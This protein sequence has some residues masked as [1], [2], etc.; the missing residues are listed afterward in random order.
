MSKRYYGYPLGSLVVRASTC[1]PEGAG[2]IADLSPKSACS[3][4]LHTYCYSTVCVTIL[5]FVQLLISLQGHHVEFF[6]FFFQVCFVFLFP[7]VQLIIQILNGFPEEV[8]DLVCHPVLLLYLLTCAE[9]LLLVLTQFLVNEEHVL[10]TLR[11]IP[12][13]VVTHLHIFQ[14][15][16]LLSVIHQ[17]CQFQVCLVFLLVGC[18]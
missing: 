4:L 5:L 12:F 18:Y 1:N 17:V 13:L 8:D 10:F 16:F 7:P 14:R 9:Y 2:S 3:V 11:M 6:L 15:Q